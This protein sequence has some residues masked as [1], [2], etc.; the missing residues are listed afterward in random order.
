MDK[1]IVE[2]VRAM[3]ACEDAVEWLSKQKSVK[4]AWADCE[5]GDWMLWL[6]GKLSGEPGCEKRKKLVLAAC[7]CARLSLKYVKKGEKRPLIAIQTA[8]KWANGKATIEE[9]RTAAYAAAAYDAAAYDAAAAVA[10]YAA[11][12]AAYDA[13]AYADAAVASAASYAAAAYAAAA[14]DAYAAYDAAARKEVLKKCSDIVR[15]HY[16]T[17]PRL[18]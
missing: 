16:P 18:A 3:G 6:L 17:A 11:A 13:A 1:R 2:K 15:K 12:Y 9:V 5:R 8:E 14:Y 10:A 7:G 4:Q